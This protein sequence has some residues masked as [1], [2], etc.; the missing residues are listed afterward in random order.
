MEEKI[1]FNDWETRIPGAIKYRKK[2][3]ILSLLCTSVLFVMSIIGCIFYWEVIVLL[4]ISAI[5]FIAVIFEWL[6]IKNNHLIIKN[7]QIEITNRFNKIKIYKI[8]IDN[9]VL[10][11]RSSFNRRSGGIIMIFLNQDNHQICKYEDMLNGA[12][13]LGVKKNLWEEKILSLG[14]KVVDEQEIIK[15]K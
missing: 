5:V 15:N 11:I 1:L 9:V 3:Y 7:N 4:L 13:P 8:N 6:K 14:I 10:K 12:S 2:N